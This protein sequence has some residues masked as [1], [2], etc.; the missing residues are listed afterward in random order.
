MSIVIVICMFL[1]GWK[2]NKKLE[3]AEI[4]LRLGRYLNGLAFSCFSVQRNVTK[5]KSLDVHFALFTRHQ[6]GNV[7][8]MER[9]HQLLLIRTT[10]IYLIVVPLEL[11]FRSLL[12]NGGPPIGIQ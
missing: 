12:C 9:K 10:Y 6:P 1:F 2:D 11:M 4:V 7:G 8:R 3:E 5:R